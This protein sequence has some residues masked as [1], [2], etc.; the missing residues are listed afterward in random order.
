MALEKSHILQLS[1]ES[2]Y[3]S[4][5]KSMVKKPHRESLSL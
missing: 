3:H 2:L 5:S 4:L 1:N